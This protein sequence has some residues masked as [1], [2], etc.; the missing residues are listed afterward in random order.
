VRGKDGQCDFIRV[1]SLEG[2]YVANVYD[3][4]VIKRYTHIKQKSINHNRQSR[5]TPQRFKYK[6]DEQNRPKINMR[7]FIKTLISF[8]KGGIWK[9]LKAPYFDS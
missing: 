9:T 3:K 7:N 4:N 2:I 6:V 5:K 1:Q 8:D